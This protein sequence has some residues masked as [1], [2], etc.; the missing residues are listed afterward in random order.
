MIKLIF[1]YGQGNTRL[2]LSEI[3]FKRS[4]SILG[5]ISKVRV[6]LAVFSSQD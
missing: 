1:Y 2:E 5:D 6:K 4:D 3:A